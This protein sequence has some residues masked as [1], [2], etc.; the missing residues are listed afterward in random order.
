LN[1][2]VLSERIESGSMCL[3][4]EKSYQAQ[5]GQRNEWIAHGSKT[6][7]VTEGRDCEGVVDYYLSKAERFRCL[8]VEEPSH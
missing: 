1:L 4:S 2:S 8:I 3:S 5:I 6:K 7:R